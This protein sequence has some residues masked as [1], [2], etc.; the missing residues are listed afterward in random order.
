M[1]QLEAVA[2]L[3]HCRRVALGLDVSKRVTALVDQTAQPARFLAR[4]GCPPIGMAA[5]GVTA[6]ATA[7]RPVVEDCAR[8]PL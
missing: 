4:A 1:L 3:R 5:N 7:A 2:Q 8:R 6:L